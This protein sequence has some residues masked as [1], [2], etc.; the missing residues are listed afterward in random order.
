MKAV[1]KAVTSALFALASMAQAQTNPSLSYDVVSIKVSHSLNFNNQSMTM[2]DTTLAMENIAMKTLIKNAYGIRE[3]L[4]VGLPSWAN[5]SRYDINA[6]MIDADPKL[7]KNL[8]RDQRRTL[9]A[10]L[11]A[12]RFHV[13]AHIED[14]TLPVYELVIAKDGP[15]FKESASLPPPDPSNPI[16]KEDDRVS[17]S[18]RHFD[19]DRVT[20]SRLSGDLEEVVDRNVVDKTGLKGRYDLHLR[21]TPNDSPNAAAD[22]NPPPDIFTALQEQLGLKLVPSKG[23]VPTLVIDH[24]ERPTEN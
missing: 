16:E 3:G 23:P 14:R 22:S 17:S 9:I 2:L 1:L 19:G 18:Q 21:W 13:K 5:S 10:N 8:T 24:I 12:D 20:I 7:Y 4:I 11:L 15:S 6:K